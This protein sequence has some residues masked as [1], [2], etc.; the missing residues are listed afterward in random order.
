[1]QYVLCFIV[2][3]IGV[4]GQLLHRDKLIP[5]TRPICKRSIGW[6]AW[7]KGDS[8]YKHKCSRAQ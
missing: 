6:A 5:V 3:V 2:V 8:T 1:M 7:R 4:L